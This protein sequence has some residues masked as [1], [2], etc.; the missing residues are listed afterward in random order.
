MVSP[1]RVVVSPL[2]IMVSPLRVVVSSLEIMVSPLRVV[3][4]PLEIMVSPLRVVVSSLEI[5]VS[6]LRVVVSSLEIVLSPLGVVVFDPLE[7]VVSLIRGNCCISHRSYPENPCTSSPY[8]YSCGNT[9]LI[10]LALNA[11]LIENHGL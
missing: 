11:P 7:T 1:L 3:V 2:E 6:P 9:R 5:M 8:V 10:G 4:S